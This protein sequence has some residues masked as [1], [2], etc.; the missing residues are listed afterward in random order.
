MCGVNEDQAGTQG[1]FGRSSSA[2]P[3]IPDISGYVLLLVHL[4][5]RLSISLQDLSFIGSTVSI[6]V[7]PNV[8]LLGISPQNHHPPPFFKLLMVSE[9]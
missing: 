8:A 1:I 3:T 9:E 4:S 6:L 5:R 7:Q 2:T